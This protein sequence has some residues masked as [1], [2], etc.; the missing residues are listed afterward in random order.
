MLR[1]WGSRDGEFIAMNRRIRARLLELAGAEATH[2]CVPVQG[3]GT[4]AIEAAIGSCCR[5][6]AS[7][8]C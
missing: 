4:F 5:A 6:T 8:W 3:S 7:C 2:V 1:D